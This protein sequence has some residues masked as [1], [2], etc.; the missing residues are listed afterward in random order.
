[1]STFTLSGPEHISNLPHMPILR[2]RLRLQSRCACVSIAPRRGGGGE[3]HVP[4][5]VSRTQPCD[6][7]AL[8]VLNLKWEELGTQ[9]K[10]L[11]VVLMWSKKIVLIRV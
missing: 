6:P 2:D 8:G 7:D 5:M 9:S 1:M 10:R 4:R 3:A 11:E